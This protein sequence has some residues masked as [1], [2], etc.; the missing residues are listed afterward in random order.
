MPSLKAIAEHANTSVTTVSLV[1]NGRDGPLRISAATRQRVLDAAQSLGYTPNIV[2]RRLR[3]V[4][5]ERPSLTI[6]VV[7]PFDERLVVSVRAAGIVRQTLDAW[8]RDEGIGSPD[9][10]IETYS[11]GH[12]DEVPSLAGNTRYNGVILLNT[13]PADDQFLA[14]AGPLPVPLVLIQ[15][16][17]DGHSW[18]NSDNRAMGRAIAEHLLSLGHRRFAVVKASVAS[19]AQ[20]AR[21][22]GFAC[23][24]REDGLDLAAASIV[25]GAFSESGGHEAT[26]R[27][28][29]G[30]ADSGDS[31]PS[32]LF[33]P[34]DLM[35]VGA[36]HALK[37]AGLGVPADVAVVGYDN[38]PVASFTDPPLTTVDAAIA[39]SADAAT[40][41]LL[42]LI[43][44]YA[45]APMTKRQDAR[46]IVR[47]SCGARANVAQGRSNHGDHRT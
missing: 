42:A 27:L 45:G 14:A 22:D 34:T 47:A 25:S 20:E 37:E 36:L 16:S 33:V 7:L 5:N 23:R 21:V 11:G 1:L 46:L 6:G 43:H 26:R 3:S 28:L 10:L 41:M 19:A 15:R 8:A 31:V 9:V 40:K 35:A 38:E 13:L 39:E 24:L 2:A 29:H 30:L 44:N 18:V 4:G 32:A 17:V 12:L